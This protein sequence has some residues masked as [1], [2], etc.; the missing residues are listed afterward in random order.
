MKKFACLTLVVLMVGVADMR[1]QLGPAVTERAINNAESTFRFAIVSDRT[2]GMRGGI[3]D[4]AIDKVGK[5]QPEFVLSV[6]DLIDGYTED[7]EVWN[8]QWDEFDAIVEKLSMPFYYVAGNHD[9]SNEL[10][11]EVWR[12]RHGRDYYHFIYKDVLFLAIN[13]DEIEGGGIGKPQVEYFDQVL[14]E[15]EDVRWTLLF[16]HRPVWSYGDRMGYD[17]IEEALGDRSYTLFSGHHHHYRY[18]ILNGMEHFTLAT[19]GGGSWMRN[20]DVGELDHITWVTM[21]E[22][23][24]EVAHIDI[25]GIYS[26]DLVS[27][28]DYADIQVLRQGNWLHVD[29]LV[30]E[31]KDFESLPVTLEL[32]NNSERT[33]TI[34]GVLTEQQGVQFEPSML[35]D[36]LEAGTSK[37]IQVIAKN[38]TGASSIATLNNHPIEFEL[39]AGFEREE[40]NDIALS[41][42][43][44][45]FLDWKHKISDVNSSIHVDGDVSDWESVEWLDVRNPQYFL[46]GWDWNGEEDGRFE[47][48]VTRTQDGLYLAVQFFDQRLIS[49]PDELSSHQDKFFI[50]LDSSSEGEDSHHFEFA[51]SGDPLL[52]LSNS[53]T[54]ES[55]VRIINGNQVLELKIPVDIYQEAIESEAIRINIGIMDHDRPENT[56]P[57]VLW[58]R[59]LWDSDQNYPESGM[60]KLMRSN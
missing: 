58:W 52:P 55:A 9:T 54:I 30:N 8:A 45:L 11:T 18:K 29:P 46:E 14:S 48:A 25:N 51:F 3:F 12:E 41:T 17:G 33:F 2:G 59:P 53:D 38:S 6:G 44:R 16:M 13:T 42:S 15:N 32:T 4:G 50:H 37:S 36:K 22:D 1:A 35:D 19:T 43:K 49:D 27:E 10:L 57:S 28:E 20:P 47:F 31:S 21:K 26:K 5:M 56:K 24:P 7:P 40:R 23:G 60:F 39:S 34:S